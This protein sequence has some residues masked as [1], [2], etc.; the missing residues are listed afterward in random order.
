MLLRPSCPEFLVPPHC[1]T[2][3]CHGSTFT[4]MGTKTQAHRRESHDSA[5]SILGKVNEVLQRAKGLAFDTGL[6]SVDN[7]PTFERVIMDDARFLPDV[8]FEQLLSG[9][10]RERLLPY[11]RWRY[12]CGDAVV[13]QA[14]LF[15]VDDASPAVS[16]NCLWVS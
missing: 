4:D 11:V 16:D 1:C 9:V 14:P 10:L 13:C 6:D 5:C 8:G 15:H 12:G 2:N 3:P 7:R